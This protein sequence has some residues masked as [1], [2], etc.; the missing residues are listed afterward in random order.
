MET[1]KKNSE[2]TFRGGK[3]A[4]MDTTNMSD[5]FLT[6]HPLKKSVLSYSCME[7]GHLNGILFSNK[8]TKHLRMLEFCQVL[9]IFSS[10][11]W[12]QGTASNWTTVITK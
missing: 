1:P 8:P 9:S 10:Q 12:F 11:F 5:W 6:S 2:V 3:A 4:T 7:L